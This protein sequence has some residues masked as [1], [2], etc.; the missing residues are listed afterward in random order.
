MKLELKAIIHSYPNSY[1]KEKDLE[2]RTWRLRCTKPKEVKCAV[3]PW[4]ELQ[5]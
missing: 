4:S 5:A 1:L 2:V 3:V